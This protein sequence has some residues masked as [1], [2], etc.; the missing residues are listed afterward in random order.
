MF[1][2]YPFLCKCFKCK[3]NKQCQFI[4]KC[5]ILAICMLKLDATFISCHYYSTMIRRSGRLCS[6]VLVLKNR[7]YLV[8]IASLVQCGLYPVWLCTVQFLPRMEIIH[9]K[10]RLFLFWDNNK[11]LRANQIILSS[12]V[13][14]SNALCTAFI[15]V[16]Q[17]QYQNR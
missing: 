5:K 1:F 17:S 11:M 8:Y 14:R 15:S 6:Y 4:L 7:V 10:L 13:S 12:L 9:L 16:Y 3:G 2:C